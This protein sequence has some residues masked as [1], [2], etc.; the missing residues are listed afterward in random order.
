VDRTALD[1]YL[2]TRIRHHEKGTVCN[3]I[4]CVKQNLLSRMGFYLFQYKST[5][6]VGLFLGVVFVMTQQMLIMFALFVERATLSTRSGLPNVA[7]TQRAM[8]VFSFF[9]FMIYASFG[10]MLYVFRNDLVVEGTQLT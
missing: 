6:A 8:A 9:L 5:L 2:D 10:L 4:L 7:A 1:N 3:G